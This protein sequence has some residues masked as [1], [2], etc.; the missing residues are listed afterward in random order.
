MI[1]IVH[2]VELGYR[3][4]EQRILHLLIRVTYFGF[5][6][7]LYLNKGTAILLAVPL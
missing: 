4:A 7:Q 6:M 5:N 2:Q 3:N 1:S